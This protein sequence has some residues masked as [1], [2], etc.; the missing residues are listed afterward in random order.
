M[1]FHYKLFLRHI[2][3]GFFRTRNTHIRLTPKRLKVLVIFMLVIAVYRIFTII[4]LFLDRI[5]FGSHRK[6]EVRQSV[7]IIGN[8]RSGSTFLH[9][10][11]AEDAELF[12]VLRSWEIYGAPTV[13]QRMFWR[14][15]A[16]A[17]N[18]IGAPLQRILYGWEERA[19]KTIKMHKI[20]IKEAEEDEGILLHIW[21]GFFVWFFVPILS[22]GV[23]FAYFDTRMAPADK[24]RVM[25]F[26]KRCLQKHQYFHGRQKHFLSKNPSFTP[27]VDALYSTFPDAKFI[28]LVRNPLDLLPS[29]LAWFSL[30]WHY[31]G[32]PLEKYPFRD[33]IVRMAKHWYTYPMNRFAQADGKSFI[34]IKYD[35]LVNDPEGIVRRI[36]EHFDFP[37]TQKYAGKLKAAS[38]HAMGYRS[39]HIN[40]LE[41]CGLS[42]SDVLKE[43]REVFDEFG[44]SD[45]SE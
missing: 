32:D 9:R 44:F 26:Y 40:S 35:D 3:R 19:L 11:M 10:L 39:P 36:Y 28:F 37:M 41:H 7:F 6:T 22:E 18:A 16:V 8:F 29:K 24:R 42:A 14:G 45:S 25:E 34:I 23:P 20:G 17:D 33:D 27:R 15:L 13:S 5:L 21:S 2:F 31:F 1:H 38:S 30:A 4:C 12:T 43:F